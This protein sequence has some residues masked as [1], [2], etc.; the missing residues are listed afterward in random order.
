[1]HGQAV[2]ACRGVGYAMTISTVHMCQC[3]A[4]AR[5]TMHCILLLNF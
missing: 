4:H 5:P 3:L 1:M 2:A